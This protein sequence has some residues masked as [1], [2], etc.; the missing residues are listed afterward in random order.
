MELIGELGAIPH[1]GNQS[2]YRLGLPLQSPFES[3]QSQDWGNLCCRQSAPD[4]GGFSRATR[5]G[6]AFRAQRAGE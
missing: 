5:Q 6:F 3:V 1:T 2:R 4:R